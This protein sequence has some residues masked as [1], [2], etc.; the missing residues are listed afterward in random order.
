MQGISTYKEYLSVVIS[1]LGA[2]TFQHM[3]WY[4]PLSRYEWVKSKFDKEH[5]K[6]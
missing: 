3:W 6:P 2:Y 5:E 4:F 1:D